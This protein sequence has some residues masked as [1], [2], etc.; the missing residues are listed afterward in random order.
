MYTF[1]CKGIESLPQILIFV[2]P[3]SLKLD[4]VNLRYFKLWL[5]DQSEFIA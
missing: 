5:F 4:G 2:I 1:L 3:V